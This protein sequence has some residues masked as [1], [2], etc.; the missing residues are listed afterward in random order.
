MAPLL[1]CLASVPAMALGELKKNGSIQPRW[2]PASHRP[3]RA[4]A[5]SRR[6]SPRRPIGGAS[7]GRAAAPTAIGSVLVAAIGP[8]DL[9]EE[10]LP[11]V[12]REAGEGR[13]RAHL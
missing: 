3:M 10:L 11:Q 7:R 2:A 9:L 6:V 5:T 8:G 4:A 13:L 1:N 12:A